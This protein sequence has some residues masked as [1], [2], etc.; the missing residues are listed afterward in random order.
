MVRGK[1]GTF[2][3]DVNLTFSHGTGD[4][5]LIINIQ[6]AE[7]WSGLIPYIFCETTNWGYQTYDN[8]KRKGEEAYKKKRNNLKV[9]VKLFSAKDFL[10]LFLNY[11]GNFEVFIDNIR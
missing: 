5:V 1:I 3:F 11:R 8:N 4:L 9:M 10:F 7:S 2:G 6:L